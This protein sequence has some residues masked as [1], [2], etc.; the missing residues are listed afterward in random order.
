MKIMNFLPSIP[1]LFGSFFSQ[2]HEAA[3]KVA[4]GHE[5]AQHTNDF[6]QLRLDYFR[7]YP[8]FYDGDPLSEIKYLQNY[9]SNPKT[10][11]ILS[12]KGALM[13]CPLKDTLHHQ[14]PFWDSKMPVEEMYYLGELVFEPGFEREDL[15]IRMYQKFEEEVRKMGYRQIALYEIAADE[16]DPRAPKDYASIEKLWEKMGFVKMPQIILEE[17]WEEQGVVRLHH[18]IAWIKVI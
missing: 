3:L 16:N 1:V 15:Q 5:V 18:L 2:E 9:A 12:P 8:Y 11:L 6:G 10:L 17:F 13:G 14:K 7:G 4:K